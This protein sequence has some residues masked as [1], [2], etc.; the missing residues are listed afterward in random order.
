L[1]TGQPYG[2]FDHRP[3]RQE[4]DR[5]RTC[6]AACRGSSDFT[7]AGRRDLLGLFNRALEE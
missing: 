1:T 6:P 2:G 7:I 5:A 3:T 4:R